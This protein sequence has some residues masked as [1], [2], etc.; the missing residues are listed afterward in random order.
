MGCELMS[1]FKLLRVYGIASGLCGFSS[2]KVCAS[3]ENEAIATFC[4]LHSLFPAQVVVLYSY[5]L[6]LL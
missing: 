3:N 5:P 6:S 1:D 4:R 2:G